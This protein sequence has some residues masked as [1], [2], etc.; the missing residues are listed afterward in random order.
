MVTQDHLRR[1]GLEDPS[2]GHRA[3]GG[4]VWPLISN[5]R[6]FPEMQEPGCWEGGSLPLRSEVRPRETSRGGKA[7]SPNDKVP[8]QLTLVPSRWWH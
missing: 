3:P 4:S 2:R 1:L 7:V 6:S 8:V 5:W